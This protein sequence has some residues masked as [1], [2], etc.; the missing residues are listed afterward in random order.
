MVLVG[1][2]ETRRTDANRCDSTR[3]DPRRY[4]SNRIETKLTFDPSGKR[5]AWC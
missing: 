1:E 2:V 4:E 3:D 5:H